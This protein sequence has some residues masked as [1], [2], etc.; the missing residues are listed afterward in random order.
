MMTK[1]ENIKGYEVTY[2]V[3]YNRDVFGNVR[4]EVE[5]VEIITAT[6]E[7]GVLPPWAMDMYDEANDGSWT[8][9][10]DDIIAELEAAVYDYEVSQL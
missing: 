8:D 5:D 10:D 9:I 2:K 4:N 6:P 3:G 1:Q 7:G